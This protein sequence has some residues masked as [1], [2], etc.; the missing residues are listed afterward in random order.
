MITSK[1]PLILFS[2][3]CE[4]SLFQHC[5]YLNRFLSL[6][7]DSWFGLSVLDLNTSSFV[8]SELNVKNP[9]SSGSNFFSLCY[10]LGFDGLFNKSNRYV[11]YQGSHGDRN[12]DI[13]NILLPSCSFVEQEAMFVN[14]EGFLQK[15]KK[16]LPRFGD[17]RSDSDV[18]FSLFCLFGFSF[19]DYKKDIN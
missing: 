19:F 17:S 18:I 3:G 5:V 15:T 8:L 6:T 1:K 9:V 10:L 2:P 16:I 4:N 11:I 14:F 13:S 7:S 12:A